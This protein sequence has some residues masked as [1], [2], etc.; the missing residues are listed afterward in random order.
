VVLEHLIAGLRQLGTILLETSQNGEV[1]LI[2]HFAAMALDVARASRL[3][4][5]RAATRLLLRESYG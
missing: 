3:F 4:F 1:A 5:R 2:H